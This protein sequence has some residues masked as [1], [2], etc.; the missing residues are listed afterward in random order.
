MKKAIEYDSPDT[1][2]AAVT[3]V[4]LL[5]MQMCVYAV[6]GRKL[7]WKTCAAMM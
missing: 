2:N 3:I 1:G 5:I 7:S 6:N 4:T